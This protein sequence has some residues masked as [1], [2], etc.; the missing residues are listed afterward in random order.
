MKVHERNVRRQALAALKPLRRWHHNCHGA[1]MTIVLALGGRVARGWCKGVDS[2]HSWAVLGD[3][4][5]DHKAT[6]VDG[7]LWSYSSTKGVWVGTLADGLHSPHGEGSIWKAGKPLPHTGPRVGLTPKAPLSFWARDFLKMVGPLDFIGWS[8]L[9]NLPVG[10][11]P[12]AE[13]IA[14]MDDTEELEAAVPIDRLGMLTDRNPG[15]VYLPS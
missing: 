4:C 10:G 11:W 6:I 15:G 5:Y 12:A 14:A 3:D 13:I 7:A 1:S 2:Q 9:A 8:R